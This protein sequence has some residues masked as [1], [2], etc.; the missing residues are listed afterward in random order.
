MNNTVRFFFVPAFR[1]WS[2]GYRKMA[3]GQVAFNMCV[4]GLSAA[5]VIKKAA[6]AYKA[7]HPDPFVRVNR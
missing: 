7:E 3:L 2:A 1:N 6:D 5:F 4:V